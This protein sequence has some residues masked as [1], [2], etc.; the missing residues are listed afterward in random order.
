MDGYRERIRENI[1]YD[2]LCRER[3]YDVEEIDGYV[4]LMAETCA[5]RRGYIRVNGEE[6]PAEL[7]RERLL[8]LDGEH[9]RYVMD[10]LRPQRVMLV[11]NGAGK[12]M[13][14]PPN[15]PNPND[16]K[17]TICGPFLLCSFEGEHFASLTPAQQTQFQA[18][19]AL[20][21]LEGGSG[22]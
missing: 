20:P 1:G 12:H 5:S 6:M 11:C 15:R 19:F 7:V 16:G 22:Q 3:P 9:I 17:D 14:L 8:K 13:G 4:E 2:L 18:Y 10:S 21:G